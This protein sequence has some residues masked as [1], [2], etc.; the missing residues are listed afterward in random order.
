MYR[1]ASPNWCNFSSGMTRSRVRNSSF[2]EHL[3]STQCPQCFR[4]VQYLLYE[5]AKSFINRYLQSLKPSPAAKRSIKSLSA[6][7]HTRTM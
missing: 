2:V 3:K 7:D 4:L 5:E 1:A 6:D